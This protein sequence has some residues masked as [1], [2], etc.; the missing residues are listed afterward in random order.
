MSNILIVGHGTQFVVLAGMVL[1]LSLLLAAAALLHRYLR[2]ISKDRER[3][4]QDLEAMTR[5]LQEAQ[6]LAGKKQQDQPDNQ[7]E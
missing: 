2:K 1:C 6:R 5:R 4:K 3:F 7:T